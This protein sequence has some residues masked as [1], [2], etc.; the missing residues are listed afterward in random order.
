VGAELKLFVFVLRCEGHLY[1]PLVDRDDGGKEG[2]CNGF[3]HVQIVL[4]IA[5]IEMVKKKTANAALFFSVGNIEVGF[6]GLGELGVEL[7]S[8]RLFSCVMEMGG[9]FIIGKSHRSQVVA[10]AEPGSF[11]GFNI[12]DI[13]VNGGRVGIVHVGDEADAGGEERS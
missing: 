9:I 5:G 6:G 7:G 13:H 4:E 8:Q 2:V 10:A 11:L 3:P 1:A 12:T